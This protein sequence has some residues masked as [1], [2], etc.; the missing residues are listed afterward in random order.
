M[1]K[2]K[3]TTNNNVYNIL[4]LSMNEANQD[5]AGNLIIQG[6]WSNGY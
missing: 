6:S 5:K 2:R 4:K 1:S 3:Y